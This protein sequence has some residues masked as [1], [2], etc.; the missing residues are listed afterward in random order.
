MSL[1]KITQLPNLPSI[2]T[3]TSNTLF[4]GVDLLSGTTG[5]FTATV[6]AQQLY[7]NNNLVVG[8]NY[9][10][11]FSNTVGQFSGSDPS[12]LQV[13][14]Q[15]FNSTGSGDYVITADTGTNMVGYI[16]LGINNSQ[17][18]GGTLFSSMNP[19][20]GYLYV[21]GPSDIGTSGNL[22][23]GTASSGANVVFV[24]GNTQSQNIVATLTKTGLVLNT[25]SYITF[26]DGSTQSSAVSNAYTQSAYAYANTIASYLSSN[27]TLQANINST[28][29]TWISSNAAF[30]TSAYTYANTVNT[31]AFSAYA[32]GNT[33]NT[34][35]YSAYAFGNTVNTYAYSAYAY[36]NTVNVYAYS[37][38][39]FANTINAYA[40]SAY[41]FANSVNTVQSG[42]NSTQNTW[43]S[44]NATF[45]QSAYNQANLANSIANTALQ[46]TGGTI[47]GS[48]T[49]TG[50]VRANN[51]YANTI[52]FTNANASISTPSQVGGPSK[53]INITA[54][55]D[56][57]QNNG[58]TI[59]ITAGQT[60]ATGKSGG[61]VVLV[62]NG[63]N[64]VIQL[65]SNTVNLTGNLVAN[66]LGTAVSF[67]NVTSNSAIFSKNVVVLGNLTAN[68]L[69]GNVFFSNVVTGTSQANS[70]LWYPQVNS[71][72]QSSGQVWY[73]ANT[74]SL[75]QD[76]DVAGDR[77]AIS[78][79]LFERV[80]NNTGSSIPNNSWVKL[81]GGVTANAVPYIQL[82]DAGS[83][84]NS[85][86][87]GFVKN[88]IAAGAYGFVYTRGIVS[89]FDASTF[90]NNGQLLFLST[91]PGQAT[92]V[93][94]TGANSVVAVAKILSNGSANGKLQVS[95]SNQQAYGKPNGAILFAN[96]NLIQASNTLFIN[97]TLGQLNVSS[98]IY[99]ANGIIYASRTY[100]STQTAITIS[101]TTD[102]WVRANVGA[103]LAITLSNFTPGSE[104]DVILTNP[105]AG[106]PGN[107]TITHGCSAINSSV[108]ATTFTLSGTTTAFL[109][110]YSFD[111]DLANTYVKVSYS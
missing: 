2:S 22:I 12:F 49:I 23:I 93:A 33:V 70:I 7:A 15:N 30:L 78:K 98:T 59:T 9:Q 45:I 34:Y 110:Y 32:F 28:Q 104:V 71:P 94:P 55:S 52:I 111:S 61:N 87:E 26:S 72:T 86:V 51:H 46:S 27:N 84:A 63:N 57:G 43:I 41:A 21:H 89:D 68:T 17:F 20:D 36:S 65:T 107:R 103:S 4:V 50:D 80:Y 92:N 24:V 47:T 39:S 102:T 66:T 44:S 82:A 8:Q 73:S 99:A 29:N 56:L 11:I 5:K 105:N 25:Q 42:I 97:E 81:A 76:T 3:N 53:D 19:Y 1:V 64:S 95:I 108:G 13:N 91:T 14:N 10:T 62:A 16:D 83:A 18:N 58:G 54:G 35:A 37:A 101:M 90:G 100:P 88:G 79:V 48:L 31:Y 60:L 75:V 38:Y 109:K 40:Y 74:I 85:Q 6:L 69:L 67:D 106:G 96:N 77:P